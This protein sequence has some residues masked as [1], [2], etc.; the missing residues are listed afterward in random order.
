V[1]AGP[2][3]APACRAHARAGRA[4]RADDASDGVT[5]PPTRDELA[6]PAGTFN[7]L[8][9]RLHA[10]VARAREFVADAGHELRTPPTVLRGEFEL[11]QRRPG[12]TREELAETVAVAAEETER[13][14]RLTDNLL[15]LAREGDTAAQSAIRP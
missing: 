7:A 9:G 6:R 11:A 2:R 8:L 1:V 4:A 13:L 3:R 12:R 14:V 5:V 10:A 15:A